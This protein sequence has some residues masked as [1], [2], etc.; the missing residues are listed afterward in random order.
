MTEEAWKSREERIKDLE[1]QILELQRR[2]EAQ[3]NPK[4][5]TRH[6]RPVH[7]PPREDLPPPPSKE[8]IKKTFQT[9]KPR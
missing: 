5:N 6:F 7:S 4:K 8:E 9:F 3:E 2:M 1:A